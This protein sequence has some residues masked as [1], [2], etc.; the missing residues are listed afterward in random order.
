M[1]ASKRD[2]NIDFIR[3]RQDFDSYF[4]SMQEHHTTNEDGPKLNQSYNL[5][6]KNEEAFLA[7]GEILTSSHL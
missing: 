2:A 1:Q 3:P 5:Y 6:F 4:I 7:R